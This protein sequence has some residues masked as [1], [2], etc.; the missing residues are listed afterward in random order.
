MPGAG[1]ADSVPGLLVALSRPDFRRVWLAEIISDAGSFVT[2]IA[3]AVYVHDL[4]GRTFAVGLALALRAIPWIFVGPVAGVI[5][6]RVD[7][8]LVMI[9][10]D[11]SRAVIVAMLPFTTAAWQAYALAFLSGVFSPAFRPARQALLPVI[12]P[13]PLYVRALAL[14]EISHQVLHT[15]GPA[16]GGAAVLW[17]GARD[18]FFLDSVSFL[19]S[20]AFVVRVGA[21]TRA[22][23]RPR[24][25]VEITGE[26]RDGAR[27]LFGDR[28][29]RGLVLARTA[30]LF[31]LEG[32]TALLLVYVHGRGLGPGAYGVVLGAAGLGTALATAGLARRPEGSPRSFAL[33]VAAAGPAL[34][35]VLVL[36]PD[37]AALLG[38]MFVVGATAAG[39]ALYVNAT[40]AE[41]VPDGAR[42][43]VF[44]LTGAVFETG[45]LGG[46]LGLAALGDVIGS[47]RAI[48]IGGPLA[49]AAAMAF[50][51]RVLGRIRASDA[52]R[53]VLSSTRAPVHDSE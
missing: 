37:Y 41:R 21:R 49:A 19:L 13:G 51:A 26:L 52:Q 46:S 47:A 42:G 31:G 27:V 25:L 9:T 6:D 22:A 39:M 32:V 8:R 14:S 16:L 44:S 2:F 53:A 29:L 20:A 10:C 38:I 24:S 35:A 1:R 50:L 34:L 4:T 30:V 5:A 17:L 15:L 7:R 33:G 28:L 43:R 3:L 40:I 36:R 48:A 18:A 11:L 12:A 23:G 45:D